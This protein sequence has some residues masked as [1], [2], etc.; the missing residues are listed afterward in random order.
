M[1][2][3]SNS[4]AFLLK[5]F[6]PGVWVMFAGVTVMYLLVLIFMY[7]RGNTPEGQLGY[8]RGGDKIE[9]HTPGDVAYFVW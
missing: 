6:A 8:T 3:V 9:T 1:G 2:S 7:R 5:P 4:F